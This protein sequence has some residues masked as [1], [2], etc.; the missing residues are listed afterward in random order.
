MYNKK[1]KLVVNKSASGV[2]VVVTTLRPTAK[3]ANTLTLTK[4]ST[5]LDLNGHQIRALLS[6]L[7]A[8]NYVTA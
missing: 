6:T 1:N 7:Q 2:K 8:A 4:G 3:K 5:R